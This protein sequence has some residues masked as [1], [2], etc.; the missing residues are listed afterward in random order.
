MKYLLILLILIIAFYPKQKPVEPKPK[1]KLFYD[2]ESHRWI[3]PDEAK[4]FKIDPR[5]LL[6]IPKD[7]ILQDS[8]GRALFPSLKDDTVVKILTEDDIIQIIDNQ[9]Y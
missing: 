8:L 1:D 2:Y 5:T 7:S 4:N 3:G 9:K 6:Y